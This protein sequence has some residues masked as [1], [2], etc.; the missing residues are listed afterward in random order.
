MENNN[1]NLFLSWSGKLSYEVA[2]YF[3]EWICDVIQSV[4]PYLSSKDTDK[5][6]RWN[7]V[8]VDKLKNSSCGVI[9]VT[10]D[11]INSKWLNFEAGALSDRFSNSYVCPFL[12]DIDSTKVGFPLAQFQ[13]TMFNKED[14]HKLI[15]TIRENLAKDVIDK[16]RVDKAFEKWYKDFEEKLYKILEKYKDN[17]DEKEQPINLDIIS[18][19]IDNIIEIVTSNTNAIN[20]TQEMIYGIKNNI[21]RDHIIPINNTRSYLNDSKLLGS[22][23]NTYF[24]SKYDSGIGNVRKSDGRSLNT[25]ATLKYKY[26]CQ[27]CGT[28]FNLPITSISQP[29]ICPNCNSGKIKLA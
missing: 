17:N 4:K 3:R 21:S 18:K 15:H 5:G 12:I 29:L 23:L 6:T 14:I 8:I 26:K 10:K 28:L 19:N 24:D 7:D 13:M 16:D 1:P 9:F 25:Y 20:S 27:E 22:N 11:N 2:N